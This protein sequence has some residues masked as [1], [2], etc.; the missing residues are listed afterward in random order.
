MPETPGGPD[1]S[2]LPRLIVMLVAIVVIAAGVLVARFAPQPPPAPTLPAAPMPAPSRATREAPAGETRAER[3]AR[4][5]G[6]AEDKKSEWVDEIP[7]A[8]ASGLAPERREIFLRFANAERCTCGCGFTLAACRRFDQEC[9]VSG[10]RVL[11]LLDSV[12]AG[13]VPDAEGIRRRPD[14]RPR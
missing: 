3:N 9:D 10:P 1:R 14:A 2:G 12:A 11:R 8:D 13:L 6:I 5:S 7:G 4:L